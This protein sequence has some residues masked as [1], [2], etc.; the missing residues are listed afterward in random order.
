M[1]FRDVDWAQAQKLNVILWKDSM[2]PCRHS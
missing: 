2:G 1:D